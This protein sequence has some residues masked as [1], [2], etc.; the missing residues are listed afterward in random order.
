MNDKIT[1]EVNE[2]LWNGYDRIISIGQ[3]VPHEVVG[4]ANHSKNILVGC[5]GSKIINFSHML[6]AVYGM[7][8]MMGKDHTPVRK[9]LDY[10]ATMFLKDLPIYYVLTVT[11]APDQKTLLHGLFMDE[12]REGFEIAVVL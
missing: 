11:T 12:G 10:A 3:I 9:V 6:G 4:M 8:R 7:E 5:G 2:S 1:V